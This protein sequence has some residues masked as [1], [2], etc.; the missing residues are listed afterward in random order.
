M[1]WAWETE[2]GAGTLECRPLVAER[3]DDLLTVFGERGVARACG[4]V[5]WRRPDGGYPDE[6]AGE[7]RLRTI[8]AEG[9][10]PG[11]IGYLGDQPVGW[12]SL[13]PRHDFPT[14]DR[15][16]TLAR[17][18]DAEVW[19]VNCF[20]TRVGYRRNG[21]GDAMLRGAVEYARHSGATVLEG[22][23]WDAPTKSAVNLYT[24]TTGMFGGHEWV[25]VARRRPHRPIVRLDL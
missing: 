6:R 7:D 4:C 15:S 23:P 22:Y 17:I 21:I 16:R 24:G 9:P 8:T 14:L 10:P 12:V 2:T 3:F 5:Y 13:G 1:T 20:V 19:S 11:L 25:E 18:D